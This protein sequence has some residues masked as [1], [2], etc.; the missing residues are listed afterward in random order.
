[1]VINTFVY[2]NKIGVVLSTA[3]VIEHFGLRYLDYF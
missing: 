1:L 3:A 2:L